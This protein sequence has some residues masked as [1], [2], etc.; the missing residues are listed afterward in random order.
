[1][2]K[3]G[4]SIVRQFRLS[5]AYLLELSHV[6]GSK[7]KFEN[8]LRTLEG[9]VQKLKLPGGATQ[10]FLALVVGVPAHF[11][12]PSSALAAVWLAGKAAL[13]PEQL[14]EWGLM[15]PLSVTTAY[16]QVGVT[17]R[18]EQWLIDA[19]LPF[20]AALQAVRLEPR[21]LIEHPILCPQSPISLGGKEYLPGILLNT[22]R[23]VKVQ[24]TALNVPRGSFHYLVGTYRITAT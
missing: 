15:H 12:K 16:L 11:I 17:D 22:E 3:D 10:N 13:V 19:S 23:R 20:E 1:M 7:A 4:G 24:L 2:T 6:E 8:E 9:K 5:R 18:A 21:M 14:D